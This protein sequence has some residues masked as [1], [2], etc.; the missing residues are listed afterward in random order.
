M[1]AEVFA[2]DIPTEGAEFDRLSEIARTSS[3]ATRA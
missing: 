3:A 1:I 2:I